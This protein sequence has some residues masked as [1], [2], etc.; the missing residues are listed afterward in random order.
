MSAKSTSE[1]INKLHA[2][3]VRQITIEHMCVCVCVL[4]GSYSKVVSERLCVFVATSN[5]GTVRGSRCIA[6][7]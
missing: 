6:Y 7:D 4:K 3:F 5:N 1:I 2:F